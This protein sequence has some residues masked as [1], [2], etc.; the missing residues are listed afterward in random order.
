[1]ERISSTPKISDDLQLVAD[2]PTGTQLLDCRVTNIHLQRQ[3]APPAIPWSFSRT[4]VMLSQPCWGWQGRAGAV[5]QAAPKIAPRDA[6]LLVFGPLTQ[7]CPLGRGWGGRS[8]S[9]KRQDVM[10]VPLQI[11]LLKSDFHLSDTRCFLLLF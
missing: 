1:M 9:R 11:R 3:A 7:S 8:I 6:R 4:Y 10:D 2:N 5:W